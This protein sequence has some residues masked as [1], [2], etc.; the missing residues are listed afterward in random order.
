MTLPILTVSRAD[1][2]ALNKRVA[3][4]DLTAQDDVRQL[5][6]AY[7]RPISCFTCN[8]DIAGDAC[9]MFLPERDTTADN[10]GGAAVPRV[11]QPAADG[12]MGA[13]AEDPE[14][15]VA[16]DAFHFRPMTRADL[17]FFGG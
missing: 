4:G 8:S 1:I 17:I 15:H 11:L 6:A 14:A 2:R 9:V 13:R 16:R 12:A 7:E 5:F 3:A 10:D